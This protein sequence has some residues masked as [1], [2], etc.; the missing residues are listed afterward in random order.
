MAEVVALGDGVYRLVDGTSSRLA[1]AAGPAHARWVFLDGFVYVIDGTIDQHSGRKKKRVD[2][3]PALASPMPATV[4]K[5]TVGAGQRVSKGEVLIVLEA[6][7]M[8]LPINAP[9][10]GTVKRVACAPGQLVEP[11]VP[12]LE[13]E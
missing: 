6:M 3:H 9:R 12:L 10:D 13:L 4:V 5:I 2:D 11:G 7:K 8:E 1:F